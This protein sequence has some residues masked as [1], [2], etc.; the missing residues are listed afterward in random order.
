LVA[1]SR[2]NPGIQIKKQKLN[3]LEITAI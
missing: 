3:L 1:N 2:I